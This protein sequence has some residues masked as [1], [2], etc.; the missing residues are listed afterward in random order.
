M[1]RQHTTRIARGV[2]PAQLDRDLVRRDA[3]ELVVR[4]L[5]RGL[6]APVVTKKRCKRCLAEKPASAFHKHHGTADG[7]QI[8]C[9]RCLLRQQ[10][11]ARAERTVAK[12]VARKAEISCRAEIGKPCG[13]CGRVKALEEFVVDRRK[14]DGHGS[15]CKACAAPARREAWTKYRAKQ[16]GANSETSSVES[17]LQ[18]SAPCDATSSRPQAARDAPNGG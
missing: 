6:T 15:T 4:A 8:W 16:A 7:L 3:F 9:K 11:L 18:T 5:V 14:P 2:E 12:A 1:S 13:H 17:A 10:R